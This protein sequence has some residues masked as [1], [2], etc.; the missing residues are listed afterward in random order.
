VA[1]RAGVAQL[2]CR[3]CGARR[4][5]T[6]HTCQPKGVGTVSAWDRRLLWKWCVKSV[7]LGRLW[8]AWYPGN[9]GC[10]VKSPPA[11]TGGASN[12][13]RVAK[14]V[15]Q[16]STLVCT[17]A[18]SPWAQHVTAHPMFSC[19][20]GFSPRYQRCLAKITS[21]SVIISGVQAIAQVSNSSTVRSFFVQLPI[22][23]KK[24]KKWHRVLGR[25]KSRSQASWL[26]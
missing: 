19:S 25:W 26:K 12:N 21:N 14:A 22:R 15:F 1:E 24:G 18:R 6:K 11:V 10:V 13:S 8:A 23:G 5:Q 4:L 9:V 17:S 7:E 3:R 16:H 2:H 20:S